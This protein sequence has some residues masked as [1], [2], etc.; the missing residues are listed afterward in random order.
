MSKKTDA[1]GVDVM[2]TIYVTL[3]GEYMKRS[4]D[5]DGKITVGIPWREISDEQA[6]MLDDLFPNCEHEI[7]KLLAKEAIIAAIQE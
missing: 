4:L 6:N 3:R 1:P 5:G 2:G 7:H